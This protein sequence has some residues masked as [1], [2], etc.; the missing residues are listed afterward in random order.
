MSYSNSGLIGN[1]FVDG[2]PADLETFKTKVREAGIDR[3]YGRPPRTDPVFLR[4]I[5]NHPIPDHWDGNLRKDASAGKI[6]Y[7]GQSEILSMIE[8]VK[9]ALQGV[10]FHD[11]RQ[12]VRYEIRNQ[13]GDIRDK[14]PCL[15]IMVAPLRLWKRL[16]SQEQP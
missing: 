14:E 7:T 10:F 4:L 11:E 15:Y 13:Y 2:I 12:I 1:C 5:M 3:A 16:T 8:P 6:P 9:Q